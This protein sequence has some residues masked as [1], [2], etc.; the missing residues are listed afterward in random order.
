MHSLDQCAIRL[1]FTPQKLDFH[2]LE[3]RVRGLVV[4][5]H[6]YSENAAGRTASLRAV[7]QILEQHRAC[8]RWNRV[9][10]LV[11]NDIPGLCRIRKRVTLR[12]RLPLVEGV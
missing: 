12:P 11:V 5:L 6:S 8:S 2:W 7:E 1:A 10:D 9:H 3:S 4:R